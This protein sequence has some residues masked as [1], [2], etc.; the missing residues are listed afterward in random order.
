MMSP[1][2]SRVHIS[3]AAPLVVELAEVSAPDAAH[4]PASIKAAAI[5]TLLLNLF[6]MST[7]RAR[8]GPRALLSIR[9]VF[10]FRRCEPTASEG[11]NRSVAMVWVYKTTV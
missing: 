9:V 2:R 5:T 6:C 10:G 7:P 3:C 1:V 4:R 11:V 8:A